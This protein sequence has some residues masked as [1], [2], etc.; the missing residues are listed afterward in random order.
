MNIGLLL[1]V[2]QPTASGLRS[3]TIGL[4]SFVPLDRLTAYIRR[5]A[6]NKPCAAQLTLGVGSKAHET[7]CR[8]PLS[9]HFQT[10][11]RLSGTRLP[12][13]RGCL[14]RLQSFRNPSFLLGLLPNRAVYK[15]MTLVD[16]SF[17]GMMRSTGLLCPPHP[18]YMTFRRLE[19]RW[20]HELT[21]IVPHV[22]LC[23]QR[24]TTAQ[25]KPE[26]TLRTLNPS[27]ADSQT[28]SK[29][30]TL[31]RVLRLRQALSVV[32]LHLHLLLLLLFN[33]RAQQR[34]RIL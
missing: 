20:R 24:R 23:D 30:D 15:G 12:T 31:R 4:I 18:M 8:L 7:P 22:L 33:A 29:A 1:G 14:Y 6:M 17:L 5:R 26:Q 13:P 3:T 2:T 25:V 19:D 10:R 16:R 32:P 34:T 28:Q 9:L 21:M 27:L 11:L